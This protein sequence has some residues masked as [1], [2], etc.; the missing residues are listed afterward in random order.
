MDKFTI[1]VI[2]VLELV[3]LIVI[4]R[5]WLCRRHRL[6]PRILWSIVLVVPV[7]GLLMYAFLAS[8]EPEKNPGRMDS[9]ADTDAFYGGGGGVG[10]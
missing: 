6:I 7:L 2:G 8:G 4:V 9:Q 10:R 5:L 3:T 1:I